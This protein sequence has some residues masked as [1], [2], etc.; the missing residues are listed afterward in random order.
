MGAP[1]T[2]RIPR[3]DYH[4][5]NVGT[6]GDGF[7][8]MGFL[9]YA[10]PKYFWKEDA[11]IDGQPVWSQFTNCFAVLHRFDAA[12]NHTGTDVRRVHGTPDFADVDV[13]ELD[14]LITSLGPHQHRDILVKL[15]SVQDNGIMHGLIY[16]T[17]QPDE[18]GEIPEWV[19][20]QP[21][22]IMFH[23]PWDSGEYST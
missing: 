9:T 14:E 2:I 16:E 19:M 4:F 3:D 5:E 1:T 8:F 22:D 7:Q 20:L 18:D 6:Y 13:A 11:P 15:F 23:P 12:G 17:G 21:R 10:A